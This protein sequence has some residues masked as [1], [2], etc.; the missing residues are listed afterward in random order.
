MIIIKGVF[1]YCRS[2]FNVEK[3]IEKNLVLKFDLKFRKSWI[4]FFNIMIF[5]FKVIL[6]GLFVFFIIFL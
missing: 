6:L 3:D 1:K 4:V 5:V 2:F